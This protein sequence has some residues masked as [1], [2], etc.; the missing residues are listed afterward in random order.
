[1]GPWCT[2]IRCACKAEFIDKAK[3]VVHVHKFYWFWTTI[4]DLELKFGCDV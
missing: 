1:M 2:F 4:C 3:N